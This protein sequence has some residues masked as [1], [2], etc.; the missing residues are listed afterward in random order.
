MQPE[1]RQAAQNLLEQH[2]IDILAMHTDA[3]A[4]VDVAQEHGIWSIGYNVDNSESYPE[5]FL[6]AAVWDWEKFY[7]PRIQEYGQGR[8]TSKS[9]WENVG[10]GI[11]DIAPLTDNVKHGIYEQWKVKRK[12]W[13]AAAM[14]C[15]MDQSQIRREGCVYRRGRACQIRSFYMDLTGM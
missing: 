13:K 9:Y 8:F 4:P 5:S 3:M 10:T 12:S 14:M 6:T 1:S 11:V 7:T 15:F 2:D